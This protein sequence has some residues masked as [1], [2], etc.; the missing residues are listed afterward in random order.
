MKILTASG[1]F[2][3]SQNWAV[4]QQSCYCSSYC[5]DDKREMQEFNLTYV[6]EELEIS[7]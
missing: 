3:N 5:I 6:E 7:S 4:S 2:S 1:D